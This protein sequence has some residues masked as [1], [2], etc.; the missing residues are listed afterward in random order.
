MQ[1][2]FCS[3]AKSLCHT[4]SDCIP[5]FSSCSCVEF[6]A[7]PEYDNEYFVRSVSSSGAGDASCHAAE[8]LRQ[9]KPDIVTH[10]H[11]DAYGNFTS[12]TLTGADMVLSGGLLHG[13]IFTLQMSELIH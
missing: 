2:R 4:Y 11:G 9:A 5:L 3:G 6:F 12:Q 1:H 8:L 13:V 7:T 10:L